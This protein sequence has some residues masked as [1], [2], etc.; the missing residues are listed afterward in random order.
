MVTTK[1]VIIVPAANG[2]VLEHEGIVD[3]GLDS[4]E[5]KRFI[6]AEEK[7]PAGVEKENT[8]AGKEENTDP[9]DKMGPEH[10]RYK[11]IYGQMKNLERK[12]QQQEADLTL[13]SQHNKRLAE[14]MESIDARLDSKEVA[15]APNPV[16]DPEGYAKFHEERRQKDKIAADRKIADLQFNLQQEAQRDAHEDYD[17]VVNLVNA[18]MSKDPDLDKKIMKSSNPPKEA[19]KIGKT[20][21]KEIEEK[22]HA[23]AQGHVEIGSDPPV[24]TKESPKLTADEIRIADL[25]GVSHEKYR[26]QRDYINSRKGA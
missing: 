15:E 18:A 19:Y 1:R 25:M 17:E 9:S 24:K 3:S 26:K 22:A 5:D 7:K 11:Q 8:E 2:F 4:W 21:L 12:T 6:V 14:Q 20:M 23:E 10:P 13:M 16:E